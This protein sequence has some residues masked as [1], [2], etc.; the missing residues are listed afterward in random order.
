M[1]QCNDITEDDE[2]NTDDVDEE[3]IIARGLLGISSSA[4]EVIIGPPLV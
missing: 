3:G 4:I 1:S 2:D